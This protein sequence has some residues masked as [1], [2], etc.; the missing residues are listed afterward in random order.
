MLNHPNWA[1]LANFFLNHPEIPWA[2][3]ILALFVGS[4]VSVPIK[5]L[6]FNILRKAYNKRV[7]VE[8]AEL[9]ASDARVRKA[10]E[11]LGSAARQLDLASLD[12]GEGKADVANRKLVGIK[13]DLGEALRALNDAQNR[14]A[15]SK[16]TVAEI[17][18]LEWKHGNLVKEYEAMDKA[19]NKTTAA[20]PVA[21]QQT[22]AS[23]LASPAPS[24]VDPVPA[25]Q[26]RI[27]KVK[28]QLASNGPD[29]MALETEVLLLGRLLVSR[30][31]D[32]PAGELALLQSEIARL[33]ETLEKLDSGWINRRLQKA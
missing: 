5:L 21:I 6:V 3:L 9:T 12:F 30:Q 7:Y 8:R 32:I 19:V 22:V 17:F 26:A 33:L 15:V 31:G 11:L 29:V 2:K 18:D 14:G 27:G 16:A 10:G 13:H 4:V 24:K 20:M 28:S 23:Q 25:I 1:P